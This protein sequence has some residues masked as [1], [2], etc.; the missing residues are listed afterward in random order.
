VIRACSVLVRFEREQS[1]AQKGS[2]L[3]L[4]VPSTASLT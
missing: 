1:A 2:D 4:L 3:P